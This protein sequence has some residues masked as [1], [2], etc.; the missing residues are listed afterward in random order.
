LKVPDA[1]RADADVKVS[2]QIEV[3]CRESTIEKLAQIVRDPPVRIIGGAIIT[4]TPS[5]RS[6]RSLSDRVSRKAMNSSTSMV[7]DKGG[8]AVFKFIL[9]IS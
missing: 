8:V 5:I 1:R 7:P 6:Q 4:A 2:K 9:H 3:L